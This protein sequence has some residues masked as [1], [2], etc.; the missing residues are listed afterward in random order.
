[1]IVTDIV[2]IVFSTVVIWK[3]SELLEDSSQKL[4]KYFGISAAIHGSIVVAIGSSFPELSSVVIS[5]LLHGE[6]NLG[7]G[8]IVGSAIFNI[9]V[10]PSISSLSTK[11]DYSATRDIVYKDAQFYIISILVLFLTFALAATYFTDGS[12]TSAVL[13]R[14]LAVIP[15]LVYCIYIFFQFQDTAE[16]DIE[17]VDSINVKRE[18]S[19]VLVSL[20]LIVGSIELMIKGVLGLGEVINAPSFLW[21]LTVVAAGTSLPDAFISLKT[22]DGKSET[23]INNAIGSNIFDLLIAIPVGI[24][25]AGESTVNYIASIPMFGYLAISTIVFSVFTRTNL[26]INNIEAVIMLL[27]YSV[28]IIW[29]TA[30]TLGLVSLV[31]GV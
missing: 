8:A 10:I 25:I 30:E 31:M 6:F 19:I 14:P 18:L 7:V 11:E 1:M 2:F 21:G 27:L 3:S 23:S 5:S 20:V 13:T 24:L 15:I 4:S 12:L 16:N 28:F 29:M 26:K 9:L 17:T 22:A